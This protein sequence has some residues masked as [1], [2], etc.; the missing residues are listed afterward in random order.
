MGSIIERERH[1]EL[2]F[3]FSSF[4]FSPTCIGSFFGDVGH[5]TF[6]FPFAKTLAILANFES[7]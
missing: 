2:A 1:R 5:T 3:F 7:Q 4:S 6:S